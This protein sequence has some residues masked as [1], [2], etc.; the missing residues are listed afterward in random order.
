MISILLATYNGERYIQ[1]A[2][3]SVL[4]QTY[5]DF[6]L[7]IGFNGTID[8]S[9]TLVSEYKDTRIRIFDY[10]DDKG[11]AKTLNKLIKEAK[12]DYICLQDDDDIWLKSKLE[13]QFHLMDEFDVVGSMIKYIDEFDNEK[14]KP[15]LSMKHEDI[16][17]WSLNG[18]NQ[19]ANTSTMFK[20]HDALQVLCWSGDL[21]GIEDYDFWLKLMRCGKKFM[22]LN[23]ELVL[24]R[25]H[26][27]SN[28]NTNKYDIN[29]IL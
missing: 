19:V 28:F 21:D 26:S 22:N 13:K 6:E 24:H 4:A 27:N 5:K 14:G 16:V 15:S 25:V 3:D 10:G 18:I 29:M 9:K 7:L 2:I 20:K 12:Y 11:K 1:K 17:Y 23:E 8:N